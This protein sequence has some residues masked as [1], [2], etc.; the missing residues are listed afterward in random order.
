[1]KLARNAL[2]NGGFAVVEA[3]SGEQALERVREQPVD[4]I[5]MDIQLPGMDGLEI[6]RRLRADP[7]TSRIPI[8][9]LSAHAK[10]SDGVKARE[11]GCVGYIT[12]PIR[13]SQFPGQVEGYLRAADGAGSGAAAG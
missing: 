12:K 3:T 11:A 8:V 4:L 2:H 10:E 5:L 1:M 7:A 9:A 13:L 6:T